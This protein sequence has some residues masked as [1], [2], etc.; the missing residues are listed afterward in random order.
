M[1][2]KPICAVCCEEILEDD[3]S[4]KGMCLD[5]VKDVSSIVIKEIAIDCLY[6]SVT[7]DKKNCFVSNMKENTQLIDKE[8]FIQ[9][10]V[11]TIEN[12]VFVSE[13]RE[14]FIFDVEIL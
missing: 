3:Y 8:L 5:C 12:A 9:N 14:V 4:Y 11:L 6:F 2:K 10:D 7:I 13:E 1:R